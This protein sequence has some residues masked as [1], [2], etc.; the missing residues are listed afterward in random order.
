MKEYIK[1]KEA[2]SQQAGFAYRRIMVMLSCD[3]MND[4]NFVNMIHLVIFIDSMFYI[5]FI[6]AIYISSIKDFY[7]HR[8]IG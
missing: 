6:Y 2:M 5:N 8:Q 3:W 7:T 1:Q 4:T